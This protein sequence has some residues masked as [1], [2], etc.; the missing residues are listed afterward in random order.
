MIFAEFFEK[1]FLIELLKGMKV[2]F[3]HIFIRPVTR[4]YPFEKRT[5]FENFR[6][7]HCL[8]R[9]SETGNE[10]CVGCSLCIRICP[11][12][13]IRMITS[14]GEI[15]QKRIDAYEIDISRCAFCGLCVE[16][17]PKEAIVFSDRYELAVY[18]A[19]NLIYDKEIL[20]R[21][22]FAQKDHFQPRHRGFNNI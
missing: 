14:K 10:R 9:D 11:N 19:K 6:G 8:M 21:I 13:A 22:G 18:D 15:N 4:L 1:I 17:C 2:V 3:K 20:L 12:N 16:V 5:M 7:L